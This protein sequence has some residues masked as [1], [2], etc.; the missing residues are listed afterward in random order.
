MPVPVEVVPAGRSSDVGEDVLGAVGEDDEAAVAD[1]ADGGGEESDAGALGVD[2]AL[3]GAASPDVTGVRPALGDAEALTA[4]RRTGVREADA[5]P[6][7]A[8]VRAVAVVRGAAV[9]RG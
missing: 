3:L 4:R 8:V 5:V 1:A 9:V 6:D 7:V 2:G